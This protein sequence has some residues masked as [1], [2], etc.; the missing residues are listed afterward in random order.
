MDKLDLLSLIFYIIFVIIEIFIIL[1]FIEVIEL[2]F[3]GLSTM[4]KRNIESRAKLEVFEGDIN[5]IILDK[6]IILDEYELEFINDEGKDKK[7]TSNS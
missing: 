3:F 6:K 4:T 2:N 5:N 1:V 7:M